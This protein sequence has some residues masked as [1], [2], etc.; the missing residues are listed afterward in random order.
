MLR[1]EPWTGVTEMMLTSGTTNVLS[2]EKHTPE[3]KRKKLRE[4]GVSKALSIAASVDQ[5]TSGKKK[6]IDEPDE[7]RSQKYT[8]D[9]Q[10]SAEVQAVL[11]GEPPAPNND[12]KSKEYKEWKKGITEKWKNK[13][14]EYGK[15]ERW[16]IKA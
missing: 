11:L 15:F 12:P 14:K 6:F 10:K 13:D 9:A 5:G 7:K 3:E 8:L 16:N 4:P 1:P 2:W